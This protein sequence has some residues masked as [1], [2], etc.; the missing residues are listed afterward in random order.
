MCA[1][2]SDLEL[3][4][5]MCRRIGHLLRSTLKHILTVD[6]MHHNI[7]ETTADLAVQLGLCQGRFE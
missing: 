3:A 5:Y 4:K 6:A 2:A 1:C 7:W